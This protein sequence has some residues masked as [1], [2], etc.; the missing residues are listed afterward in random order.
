VLDRALQEA[1]V[2]A[3]VFSITDHLVERGAPVAI[4]RS[5]EFPSVGYVRHAEVAGVLEALRPLPLP[6]RGDD[7]DPA[8][9]LADVRAWLER[10][11]ASG[12]DLVC[13]YG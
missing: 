13:F 4:P 3:S 9:Y 5:T 1:E 8:V 6:A 10:C 2:Q 11:A 7:E 12:R